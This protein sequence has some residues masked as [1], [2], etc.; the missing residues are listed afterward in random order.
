[1][2]LKATVYK[3]QLQISD[4]DR[5]YYASHA[6]TLAQHPSETE[7]RLLVR[8]LAFALFADERLQF[9]RGLSS[10]D[11]PDLWQTARDG[12]IERWIELG[13]PDEARI[14]RAC[15]RADE[16]VVLGYQ[17][18]AFA[19]W[20][21]K[22]RAALA[23]CD[24]LRVLALEG[25]EALPALLERSMDLQCLLEEGELQLIGPAAQVTVRTRPLWPDPASA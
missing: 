8:L 21:E 14:R 17:D 6:L 22:Q 19:L 10:D 5:H 2:A 23:R 24:N 16:V 15:G 11:E 12:R 1:M 9:G 13:Q 25:C 4:L 18:R 3:A 20:W 7:Q